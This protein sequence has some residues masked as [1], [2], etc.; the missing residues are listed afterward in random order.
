MLRLQ[1]WA[2]AGDGYVPWQ[3]EENEQ[4]C[5][6]GTKSDGDGHIHDP[7]SNRPKDIN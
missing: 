5:S 2:I 4:P 3:K 1:E 6:D 7:E